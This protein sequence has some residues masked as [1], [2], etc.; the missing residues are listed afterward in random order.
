MTPTRRTFLDTL[1]AIRP[2]VAS[3]QVAA[4]WDE[5]SMLPEFSVR[6]LAGHVARASLTVDTYL[7]RPQPAG[8][9]PISPAAYYANLDADIASSLNIGI[10]QRGEE[11][12]AAGHERLVAEIDR[13]AARVEERLVREPDDR[14]LMVA[15]NDLMRLDDYLVTRIVELTVHTDDLALS[16][17]LDSPTFPPEAI[18]ITIDT[19][20]G[21]A[22]N[23]HGDRAVLLALSRRERDT[24]NALRVF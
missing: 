15:G 1:A 12:A 19:L 16:V 11:L 17:G 24:V 13:L 14:L 5:P 3:P 22:R 6:G 10:R 7:D 4:R 21:I 2:V 18:D 23:R 20:V 8:G 9:V